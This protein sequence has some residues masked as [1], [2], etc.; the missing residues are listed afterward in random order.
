[1]MDKHCH[2]PKLQGQLGSLAGPGELPLNQSHLSDC[3]A[4]LSL[5]KGFFSLPLLPMPRLNT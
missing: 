2:L 4:G 3:T 1:M 5:F